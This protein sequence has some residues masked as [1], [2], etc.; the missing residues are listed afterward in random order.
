[1]R[2][3]TDFR[4]ENLSRQAVEAAK[5][6]IIDG[7]GVMLAGSTYKPLAALMAGYVREMGALPGAAS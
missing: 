1:M 6:G 7:V 5:A 3:I 2:F 4:H